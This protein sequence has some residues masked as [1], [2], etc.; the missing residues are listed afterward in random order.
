MIHSAPFARRIL[1]SLLLCAFAACSARAQ[2]SAASACLPDSPVP[3]S[4][5][6]TAPNANSS[7]N[8]SQNSA[9]PVSQN[10]LDQNDSAEP[11][12]VT[13]LPHSETGGYWISAQANVIFQWHP[14]FHAK[15]TGTNS[16]TPEAQSA[17]THV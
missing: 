12:Q 15:Y 4:A 2:H 13:L 9:T 10:P 3:Q 7:A 16:M 8:S 5:A 14:S 1:G 11:D 6:S 17:T